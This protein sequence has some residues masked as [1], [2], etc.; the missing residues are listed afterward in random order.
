MPY[1]SYVIHFQGSKNVRLSAVF[2]TYHIIKSDDG[3]LTAPVRDMKQDEYTFL[4]FVQLSLW[5]NNNNKS[6]HRVVWQ[7]FKD[8]DVEV[9]GIH[10]ATVLISD[11]SDEKHR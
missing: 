11:L 8:W 3:A 1:E 7:G 9:S 6:H 4:C 10:Q 2:D 5:T